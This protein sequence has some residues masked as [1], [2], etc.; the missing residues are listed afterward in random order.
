MN[1]VWVP[2]ESFADFYGWMALNHGELSVLVHPLTRHEIK[3]HT[4]HAAW[5]GQKLELNLSFL[6]H[7][8]PD[9]C[10]QYSELKMGYSALKQ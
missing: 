5:L 10:A 1:K 3:D 2:R 8:A 6:R 7:E 4:L 9:E